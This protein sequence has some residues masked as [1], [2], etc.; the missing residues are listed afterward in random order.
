M[1]GC[2][3]KVIDSSGQQVTCP[4]LQDRKNVI[5]KCAHSAKDLAKV[6]W[7]CK[8]DTVECQ[9]SAEKLKA[10]AVR[11]L[12]YA[13]IRIAFD[14]N[15]KDLSYDTCVD[16]AASLRPSFLRLPED[17]LPGESW[18]THDDECRIYRQ[19][20]VAAAQASAFN[21]ALCKSDYSYQG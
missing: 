9:S 2:A 4:K 1:D 16:P 19:M 5:L 17:A 7:K 3:M 18:L 20:A 6:M 12:V 11:C 21:N 14:K 15:K 13:K 8:E 10:A